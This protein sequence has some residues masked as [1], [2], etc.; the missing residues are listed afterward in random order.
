[1]IR[2]V[3]DTPDRIPA[4]IFA[5]LGTSCPCCAFWRGAVF[6]AAVVGGVSAVIALVRVLL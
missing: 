4:R 5:A 6:G 1:M 3:C 2:F